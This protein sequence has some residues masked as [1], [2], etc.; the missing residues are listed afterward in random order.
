MR[1]LKF[2]AWDVQRGKYRGGCDNLMLDLAG[3]L[4]WQFGYKEPD[5]LSREEAAGYIVEQYTGL[6]DKEG[7]E[8]YEGDILYYD[9]D[10]CEHCGKPRYKH[11]PPYY[12]VEWDVEDASFGAETAKNFMSAG[13]WNTL[14]IIGNI[15]SN[16][17]LL[18]PA[19]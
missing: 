4:Y 11:D 1:K 5:M 6:K 8:I 14:E 10:K 16:P 2:R 19:P 13:I 9:G 3:N 18:R 15:H 17:E 7:R 12:V